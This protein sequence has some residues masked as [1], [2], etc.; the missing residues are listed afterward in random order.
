MMVVKGELWLEVD[1][2]STAD[3]LQAGSQ[4]KSSSLEQYETSCYLKVKALKDRGL[5]GGL[6]L[7]CHSS[8]EVLMTTALL[9]APLLEV[10]RWKRVLPLASLCLGQEDGMGG[11]VG[12]RTMAVAQHST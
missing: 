5:L 10:V 2:V 11:R 3:L 1:L 9:V 6:V 12:I 4:R 7:V 8:L